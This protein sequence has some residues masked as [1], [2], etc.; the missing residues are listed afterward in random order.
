MHNT[1]EFMVLNQPLQ[2][3]GMGH[4]PSATAWCVCSPQCPVGCYCC[5][6]Q[7]SDS[8]PLFEAAAHGHVDILKLMLQRKADPTQKLVSNVSMTWQCS[9]PVALAHACRIVRMHWQMLAGVC[10][11]H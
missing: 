3:A 10:A 9:A 1:A 4:M 7:A 6:V 2:I 8:T 11:W 5:G